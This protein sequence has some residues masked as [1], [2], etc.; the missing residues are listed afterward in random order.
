M[1]SAAGV[2][3][4]STAALMLNHARTKQ[5]ALLVGAAAAV[6]TA[7]KVLQVVG[8]VGLRLLELLDAVPICEGGAQAS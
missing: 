1:R 7:A 3:N 2:C 4:D 5:H 6:R 8:E